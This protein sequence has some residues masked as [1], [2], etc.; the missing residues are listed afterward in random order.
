MPMVCLV[1]LKISITAP[2]D[3]SEFLKS[4]LVPFPIKERKLKPKQKVKTLKKIISI[5]LT[6]TN[7]VHRLFS[8]HKLYH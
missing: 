8:S 6:G 7:S 3:A 4:S 2:L 1:K 5:G